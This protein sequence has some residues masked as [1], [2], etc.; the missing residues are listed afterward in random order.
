[1][2]SLFPESIKDLLQIFPEL[3]PLGQ[4]SLNCEADASLRNVPAVS[5]LE[6]GAL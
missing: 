6:T 5:L 1:M 2:L 3:L 4:Q